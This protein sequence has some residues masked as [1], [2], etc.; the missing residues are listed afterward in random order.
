MLRNHDGI[1]FTSGS[2]Y[3]PNFPDFHHADSVE[4]LEAVSAVEDS[5]MIFC[6]ENP[7]WTCK[8]DEGSAGLLSAAWAPDSRHFLTTTDFHLRITIWSVSEGSVSYLKLPKACA[9]N[10]AFCPG[11]RYLAL[12]ERRDLKDHLSLFDCRPQWTLVWNIIL[13]TD[14][15]VNI[16]WSPDGR[17]ILICDNC[18]YYRAAIY[19]LLGKHL[20][21]YC[22]YKPDEAP[23]GIKSVSW[24]PTGQLLALG[25]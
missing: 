17:Y 13:D 3:R 18:L 21:T 2:Q 14:D 15:A 19:N 1:I 10:L 25:R 8:V 4:T 22:A 7:E 11:G 20:C 6:L 12:L 24:S 5:K 16:V 23:L 9:S